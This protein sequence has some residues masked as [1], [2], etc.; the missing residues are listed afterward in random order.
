VEFAQPL[1]FIA[2]LPNLTGGKGY[3]IKPGIQFGGGLNPARIKRGERAELYFVFQNALDTTVE[4]EVN[5][6][7]PSSKMFRKTNISTVSQVKIV[8]G[9]AE[10]E[11]IVIPIQAALDTPDGDY[12]IQATVRGNSDKDGRRIRNAKPDSKASYAE[13]ATKSVA[14]SAIASAVGLFLTGRVVIRSYIP[15]NRL[16]VKL[17]VAGTAESPR[18]KPLEIHRKKLWTVMHSKYDPIVGRYIQEMV[19]NHTLNAP[20]RNYVA[21]IFSRNYKYLF[22]S[23]HL[24]TSDEEL[25]WLGRI[26]HFLLFANDAFYWHNIG[27]LLLDR[28]VK[29]LEQDPE[30]EEKPMSEWLD[31]RTDVLDVWLTSFF[32][33]TDRNNLIWFFAKVAVDRFLL[34]QETQGKK[35]TP[36][37]IAQ[38][39]EKKAKDI[40]IAFS[41]LRDQKAVG[42]TA[43]D[44]IIYFVGTHLSMGVTCADQLFDSKE[45]TLKHL[46][47]LASIWSNK[48]DAKEKSR[49]S[50]I[51]I[52]EEEKRKLTSHK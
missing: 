13:A 20:T 30:L 21:N 47:D 11:Q 28:V 51:E 12:D 19:K 5:V 43:H 7:V 2:M 26:S 23:A 27:L 25:L 37:D 9:P 6:V 49:Q 50:M 17:Q 34:V 22:E 41:T 40:E 24:P 31:F 8:L 18:G 32:G 52:I 29:R 1:D 35:F 36:D 42:T 10:A 46:Q 38:A 16:E 4:A 15:N 33:R 45:E 44:N 39:E 48:Q 3:E 14:A